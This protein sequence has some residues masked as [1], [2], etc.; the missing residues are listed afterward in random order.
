MILTLLKFDISEIDLHSSWQNLNDCNTVG[1]V[2]ICFTEKMEL[3]K[4]SSI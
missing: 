1:N 4:M 2:Q 3:L